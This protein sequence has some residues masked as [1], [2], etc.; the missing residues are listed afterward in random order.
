ML[1]SEQ[2]WAHIPI[3]WEMREVSCEL[4]QIVS[5]EAPAAFQDFIIKEMPNN[6]RKLVKL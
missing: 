5:K 4:F 2:K 6:S 3:F 1:S